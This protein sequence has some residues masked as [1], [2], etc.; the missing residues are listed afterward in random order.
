MK[1]SYISLLILLLS[2]INCSNDSSITG[3]AE[4]GN[5]KVAG[6]LTDTSG[7]PEQNII[8]YLLPVNLNPITT[9]IIPDSL[10]DTTGVYG[11]YKFSINDSGQYNIYINDYKTKRGLFIRQLNL[12]PYDSIN[13]EDTLKETE[14]LLI[15]SPSSTI[16]DTGYIFIPGTLEYQ[17][18][19]KGTNSIEFSSLPLGLMPPVLAVNENN[20]N[21]TITIIEDNQIEIIADSTATFG[22][23][24]EWKYSKSI[25][26]NTSITGSNT[27]SDIYN[28]PLLIKLNSGNFNFTNLNDDGSDIRFTRSD[29]IILKHEIE[30]WDTTNK[31]ALIWVNV[32]TIYGNNSSQSIKVLWG[33]NLASSNNIPGEV[34][35]TANGY[36]AVWHFAENNTF[37]DVTYHSNNGANNGSFNQSSSIGNGIYFDGGID[38]NYIEVTPSASLRPSIAVTLQAWINPD[39]VNTSQIESF[40]SYTVDDSSTESGFSFGYAFGNWKFLIFTE[41]MSADDVNDNP[42]TDIPLDTWSLVTG[43]YDGSTIKVFLN[44]EL[45]SSENKTGNIDWSPLPSVCRIGMYKDSNETYE[46]NGGIDE[47]RVMNKACSDDWIKLCYENQKE[48]ST[49]LSFK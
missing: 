1:H 12:I 11:E 38:D 20:L 25:S 41:D 18:I 21:N 35:D 7:N 23:L 44:G 16:I 33:N 6:M 27:D 28:F 29:S 49:V 15:S 36:A 43:T 19:S 32:D 30:R 3:T 45:I 5:A 47:L 46:F 2:L 26:I 14:R 39:S 37:D 17:K 24:P 40:F 34:F 22:I 9:Q 48:N 10:V 31:Q 4:S 8:V 42:G 13:R